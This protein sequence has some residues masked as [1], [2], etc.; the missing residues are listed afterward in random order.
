[1]P[2]QVNI[3][4]HWTSATF[5]TFRSLSLDL[6]ACS[7][8]MAS[9]SFP[10]RPIRYF[11]KNFVYT[12]FTPL[13]CEIFAKHSPWRSF[14]K[15]VDR[16][17]QF[18]N[19]YMWIKHWQRNVCVGM[20]NDRSVIFVHRWRCAE[21][22]FSIQ[23]H[24]EVMSDLQFP[25]LIAKLWWSV[26]S[27]ILPFAGLFV[28]WSFTWNAIIRWTKEETVCL[29]IAHAFCMKL[30]VTTQPNDVS[31]LLVWQTGPALHCLAVEHI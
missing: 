4:I 14:M 3:K 8:L 26:F 20:E 31:F 18:S 17:Q 16:S 30:Q 21:G 7:K 22:F 2:E 29:M 15:I 24:W 12:H 10:V 9:F 19:S 23:T 6:E 25:R 1:M 11:L 27:R 28:T 13:G 5:F